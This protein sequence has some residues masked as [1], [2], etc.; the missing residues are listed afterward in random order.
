MCVLSR[1]QLSAIP[2]AVACQ[3]LLSM[4]VSRQEYWS[5]LPF[6]PLRDPPDPR[7]EPA[8]PVLQADSLPLEPPGKPLNY[9]GHTHLK[10]A[11]K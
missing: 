4:G 10:I 3:A 1:I 11:I 7:I 6:P 5:G 8:A 9:Q 2:R